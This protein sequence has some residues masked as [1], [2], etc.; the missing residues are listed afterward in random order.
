MFIEQLIYIRSTVLNAE[1]T[2]I[3]KMSSFPMQGL[4]SPVGGEI[5]HSHARINSSTEKCGRPQF[6][7]GTSGA[8][9]IFDGHFFLKYFNHLKNKITRYINVFFAPNINIHKGNTTKAN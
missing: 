1:D 3:G 4:Y 9:Q 7:R 5:E 8:P 2:K 6:F